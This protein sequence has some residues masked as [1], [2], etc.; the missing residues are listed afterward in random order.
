MAKDA[1]YPARLTLAEPLISDV[2]FRHILK[3][4]DM[5]RFDA[6]NSGTELVQGVPGCDL[7]EVRR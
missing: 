3:V 6:E 2:F 5:Q 1:L 7:G 4:L